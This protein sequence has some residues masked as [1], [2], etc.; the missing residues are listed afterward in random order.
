MS[1]KVRVKR[2]D[3]SLPV[4]EYKTRGAAGF[5][6]SAR[7]TTKIPPRSIGYIPLNVAV[8]T[9]KGYMML[10]AARG[11]MHKH[12]LMPAHGIGIGDWDYRGDQDEYK[13]PAYN[14]TGKVVVIEKGTRI[15]QGIFVKYLKAGLKDV[16]KLND[17][18]RGGFGSTGHK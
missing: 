17:K 13:M 8:E 1:K 14:F 6:L 12:G 15:A 10:L 11:S 2:F 18:N 9:P 16:K 3:K 5:D 7:E 4:P